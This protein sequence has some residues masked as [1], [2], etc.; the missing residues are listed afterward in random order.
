VQGDNVRGPPDRRAIISEGMKNIR[1]AREQVD[2]RK[3]EF[4]PEGQRNAP[5]QGKPIFR[6]IFLGLDPPVEYGAAAAKIIEKDRELIVPLSQRKRTDEIDGIPP[7]GAHANDRVRTVQ[8]DFHD[9]S[10][11]STEMPIESLAKK[12]YQGI[13]VFSSQALIEDDL[14]ELL[15]DIGRVQQR[16]PLEP[17]MNSREMFVFQLRLKEQ[18]HARIATDIL[19]RGLKIRSA[20]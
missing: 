10:V 9:K 6:K 13:E 11:R 14:P 4:F 8:N 12:I 19:V 7:D 17:I 3:I 5:R 1:L 20:P 15:E 16:F 18:R 2:G